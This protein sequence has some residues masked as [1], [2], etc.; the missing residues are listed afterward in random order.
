[1]DLRVVAIVRAFSKSCLARVLHRP[2]CPR[3]LLLVSS[4]EI[5]LRV[6]SLGRPGRY[7]YI[8]TV[9]FSVE[10]TLF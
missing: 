5:L 7:W 6:G 1:M 3:E 8:S 4:I 10:D 9:R 2:A